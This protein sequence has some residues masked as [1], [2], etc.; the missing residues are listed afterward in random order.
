M[1]PPRKNRISLEKGPDAVAFPTII[2]AL[3]DN[4]SPENSHEISILDINNAGIG[5]ACGVQLHVGQHIFF[6]DG[7][8]EWDFP[9]YG[10]V[11]WTFKNNDGFRAGIKFA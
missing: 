2:V 1:L 4:P 7:H 3:S 6:N 10:I 9:Q 8:P 5:I 11:M